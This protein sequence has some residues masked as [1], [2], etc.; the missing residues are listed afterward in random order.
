ME[1]GAEPPFVGPWRGLANRTLEKGE[2][3]A[4]PSLAAR[5]PDPLDHPDHVAAS[6]ANESAAACRSAL[7]LPTV[8]KRAS[9][10]DS[11]WVSNPIAPPIGSLFSLDTNVTKKSPR[12]TLLLG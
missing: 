8:G 2:H 9:G 11:H 5:N 7:R 1:R 12:M 3:N 4:D 6:L 10:F